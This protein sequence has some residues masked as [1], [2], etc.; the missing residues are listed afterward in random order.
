M[1][2]VGRGT[3]T[4]RGERERERE[5]YAIFFPPGVTS[6]PPIFITRG[7]PEGYLKACFRHCRM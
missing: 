7:K 2:T 1:G 6:T 3:A 4:E 5:S